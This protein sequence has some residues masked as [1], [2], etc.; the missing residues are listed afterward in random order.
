MAGVP[1]ADLTMRHGPQSVVSP[2]EVT[3]TYSRAIEA[4]TAIQPDAPVWTWFILN[5]RA[6]IRLDLHL[7][8]LD[9]LILGLRE[10]AK[11][12]PMGA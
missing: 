8:A 2:A 3:I 12:F 1:D 4:I 6:G 11:A 7:G 10:A 9:N 5:A